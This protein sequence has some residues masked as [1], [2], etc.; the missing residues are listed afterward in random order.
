M[1]EYLHRQ[2]DDQMERQNLNEEDEII[3]NPAYAEPLIKRDKE[4]S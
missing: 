1:K 3:C 2:H 4:Q